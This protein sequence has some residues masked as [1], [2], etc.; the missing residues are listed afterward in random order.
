MDDIRVLRNWLQ[1]T[2]DFLAGPRYTDTTEQNS[3]N[4]FL[5]ALL[6]TI[7][8]LSCCLEPEESAYDDHED[9]FGDIIDL[10]DLILDVH[11]LR[12]VRRRLTLHCAVV[13]PAYFVASKCRNPSIRR[14]A[15]HQ[16]RRAGQQGGWNGSSLANVA[17][18]IMRMEEDGGDVVEEKK[19]VHGARLEFFRDIGKVRAM[20]FIKGGGGF[21][22][23]G[24]G[25]LR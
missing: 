18:E 22:I 19:R 7:I 17:A 15:I 24:P 5:L 6:T 12:P 23:G 3:S 2:K 13:E 1:S 4:K 16:L 21:G 10:A 14:Q 11:K 20:C 8:K 25:P 9:L